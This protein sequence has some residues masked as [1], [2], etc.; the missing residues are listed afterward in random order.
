VTDMEKIAHNRGF[1]RVQVVEVDAA[2]TAH[3]G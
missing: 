1:A 2:G 3:D